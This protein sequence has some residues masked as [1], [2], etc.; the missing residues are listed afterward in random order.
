MFRQTFGPLFLIA[1]IG[2]FIQCKESNNNSTT[3]EA[4]SAPSIEE[5]VAKKTKSTESKTDIST[6]EPLEIVA[7]PAN[8]NPNGKEADA[9][10]I[11]TQTTIATDRK[12]EPEKQEIKPRKRAKI[13][14]EKTTYQ[15]GTIKEGEKIKHDF[16]FKNTGNAP[17]LIKKVEVSCGCTFPSYPF[18]PIEP[19]E[20]GKIGVTFN[21]E[22]KS[23]RQKPTVTIITNARPR[24]HKLFLEGFVE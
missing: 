3:Q 7:I 5:A 14:F 6:D 22:H 9:E 20:K 19:G 1:A 4:K 8:Q 18:I 10:K 21:S 16:V 23:G 13:A 15:F 24:T 17:L 2:F 11:T 12:T